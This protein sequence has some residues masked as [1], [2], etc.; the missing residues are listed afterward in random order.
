MSTVTGPNGHMP[1]QRAPMRA[2]DQLDELL[3]SLQRGQGADARIGYHASLA[4]DR[5]RTPPSI[6][7]TGRARSGRST[8]LHALALMSAVET[9]P[10]DE[11]GV[12]EPELDADIIV[13]VLAGAPS[14]ADVRVLESLDRQRV[15]V[16]LNKADAIGERWSDAVAAANRY[17]RELQLPALPLV[18][19]LATRT[20]AGAVTDADM[21]T[22]GRHAGADASFTISAE[23]FTAESAGSDVAER[24]QLLQRWGLYGVSCALSAV[25]HQPRITGQAVLQVLHSASAIDPLYRLLHRRYEQI[26]ALGGGE[27]LDELARLAARAVPDDGGQARDVLEEYLGGDQALWTGLCAGLA[28][29]EVA[30]LAAGYPAPAP[31][32]AD[33]ALS[34]AARWRAVLASDMPPAAR[35][36]ALRVHNGYVRSWERMSSAG[37]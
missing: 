22:L 23:L 20:R 5:W 1:E 15:I 27:M 7:V 6:Q 37:H 30:H 18:G 26:S 4:V 31:A 34:R 33:D 29:P 17:S 13:Y 19:S 24:Q 25:H 21:T 32:D 12:C 14:P 9:D 35:R 36:A 8:L 28:H 16:V 11:P 3:E 10:I 2:G